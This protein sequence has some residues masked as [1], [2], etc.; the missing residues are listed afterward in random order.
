MLEKTKRVLDV[1]AK[2]EFFKN[3]DVRFVGG[4]A[5]SYH[6]GHRLSEDLDFAMLDLPRDE[7]HKLMNSYGAI[8]VKH[9]QT[10]IDYAINDGGDMYDYY[11]KYMLNDVKVEF[12]SPPFNI[13]EKDIWIGKSTT[14]YEDT[15]LKIAS[16][17]TI[18]YMKSM[19]FWNRKK[20][21][22]LF[23]VYF[24]LTNV[25]N[26]SVSDFLDPYLKY[27]ITYTKEILYEKIKSKT[28]FYKKQT[29]EEIRDLVINPQ[30]YEWYRSQIENIIYN[31]FLDELY[32][33]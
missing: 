31:S 6:I 28:M 20:Y 26:Y 12:F 4:T 16:F 13:M 24:A 19:A 11:L 17:E 10:A 27:N 23:D 21:R 15:H 3:H 14:T 32:R 30:P 5:L 29:D 25:D 18:M 33:D 1:L 8:L 2:H 22:D 7:I 9:N